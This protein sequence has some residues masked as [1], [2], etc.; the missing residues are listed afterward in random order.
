MPTALCRSLS[1]LKD[2]AETQ[3]MVLRLN[4]RLQA[5]Q[6]RIKSKSPPPFTGETAASP[7]QMERFKHLLFLMKRVHQSLSCIPS[8]VLSGPPDSVNS[9]PQDVTCQDV[10]SALVQTCSM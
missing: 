8:C 5:S 2:E 1:I 3:T 7:S 6:E 4:T 10:D 9:V